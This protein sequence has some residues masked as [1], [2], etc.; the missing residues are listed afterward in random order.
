MEMDAAS[1]DG[2]GRVP[3]AIVTGSSQRL[4]ACTVKHLHQAGYN[5]IIHYRKSQAQA[6][7]LALSL[8]SVR[9]DS[10][11]TLQADLAK[12]DTEKMAK[13]LIDAS[14]QKWGRLDV[15]VNNASDFFPTPLGTVDGDQWKTVMGS[16]LKAPFFLSQ[17]AIPHLKATKGCIINL[18]DIHGQRPLSGYSV[19]CIA[20]AG[21]IMS[22]MALAKDLAPDIRVN[23]VAPG[24]IL[25]PDHEYDVNYS[26][27][28]IPMGRQGSP[29]DIAKAIIFLV[30]EAPYVTGQVLPVDGGRSLSQ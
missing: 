14:A 9:P 28:R 17:A 24:D 19:Y 21:L 12:G 1:G 30:K 23:A 11:A 6:E 13:E 7:E 16:N 5:V 26:L 10:A 2:G 15:L 27:S 18:A 29:E 8:N 4:G 20:K 3:V 22:T 25:W